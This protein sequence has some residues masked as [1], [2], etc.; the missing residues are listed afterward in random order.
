MEP[1]N[2]IAQARLDAGLTTS[3]LAEKLDVDKTTLSNWESGR[4]QLALDRLVQVAEILNVS[5]TYLLGLDEYISPMEPVSP[6]SLFVLHRIPV[7]MRSRGWALVNSIKNVLVFA[8]KSELP[9]IKIQEPVYMVAPAFSLSL[10]GIGEPLDIAHIISSDRVWVEPISADPELAGEL[11]GWYHSSRHRCVEN[12][13]GQRF[14]M[15]TYGAKWL[16]YR[17]C[18]MGLDG[19]E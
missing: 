5:V 19:S 9:F 10:R 14:Y 2:R 17:S 12:E 8:D 16:A 1:T 4:R 15:D 18:L 6:A 3:E 7:W 11:R 13:Y